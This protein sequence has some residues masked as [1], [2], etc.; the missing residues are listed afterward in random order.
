MYL[1]L[2]LY[3]LRYCL[4]F[5]PCYGRITA[6]RYEK[7][8]K[9]GNFTENII[10]MN[11]IFKTDCQVER[12]KRDRAIYDEYNALTAIEGQSRTRV[13]EYLMKKYGIHSVGT[14]YQIRARVEKSIKQEEAV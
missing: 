7:R 2:L 8:N 11:K 6:Q 5:A 14:I 13:N 12:E 9:I 1:R 3:K 10:I 4:I